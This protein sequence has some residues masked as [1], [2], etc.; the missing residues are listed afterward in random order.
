MKGIK[1]GS[2]DPVIVSNSDVLAVV[3]IPVTRISNRYSCGGQYRIDA[4][5]LAA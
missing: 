1:R 4:F 3:T 5:A 2:G